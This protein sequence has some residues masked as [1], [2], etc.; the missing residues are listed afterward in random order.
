[1][2]K[3]GKSLFDKE[4]INLCHSQGDTDIRIKDINTA[5]RSVFQ[6]VRV[7][8]LETNKMIRSLS[9]DIKCTQIEILELKNII[10]EIKIKTH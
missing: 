10:A 3:P 1:M 9:K 8:T 2:R 7:N 6:K 5:T 4:K